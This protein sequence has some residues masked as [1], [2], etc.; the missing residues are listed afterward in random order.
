MNALDINRS[1][2]DG[3]GQVRVPARFLKLLLQISL[4]AA[5]FD[6]DNYIRENPDVAKAISHG[7]IESARLHYIGFGFFE[8][9]RGG[10]PAVDADWYLRKY[11]DVALAVREGRIK[12]AQAHFDAIG[13][14]EGRSP[15]REHEAEAA[16]WKLALKGV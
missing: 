8:G 1:L 3:N 5:E 2:L 12:S 10:G 15:G 14:G 6:E 11:P 9:R 4:A 7:E 13:G 16:Q